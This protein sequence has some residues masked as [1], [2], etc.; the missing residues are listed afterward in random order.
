MHEGVT[1]R[2][3]KM[4]L[5]SEFGGPDTAKECERSM[6]GASKANGQAWRPRVAHGQIPPLPTCATR[7]PHMDGDVAHVDWLVFPSVEFF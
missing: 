5:K 7:A 6:R 2:N 1:I 4:D 3:P